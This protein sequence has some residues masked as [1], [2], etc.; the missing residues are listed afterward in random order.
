MRTSL[1]EQ[2]K[3]D[4]ESEKKKNIFLLR[5]CLLFL[6]TTENVMIL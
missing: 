6:H 4:D 1:N 3:D 2:Q 5:L